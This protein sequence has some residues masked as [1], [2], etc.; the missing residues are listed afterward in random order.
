MTRN[1]MATVFNDLDVLPPMGKRPQS[2]WYNLDES[3]WEAVLCMEL[4]LAS[5]ISWRQTV[6]SNSFNTSLDCASLSLY[7]DRVIT[8]HL[9]WM[10]F[11]QGSAMT[12]YPPLTRL[13]WCSVW[14]CAGTWRGLTT[15]SRKQCHLGAYRNVHGMF[16]D[17][18]E[19][20]HYR[21]NGN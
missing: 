10:H 13:I 9:T 5:P 6:A 1:L 12:P 3:A 11:L 2:K 18:F 15:C 14:S 19:Y 16:C 20:A 17:T 4:C 21:S 8:M 7:I